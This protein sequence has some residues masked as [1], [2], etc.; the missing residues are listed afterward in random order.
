MATAVLAA[1]AGAESVTACTRDSR[2]GR[3][4]DI[5]S[6]TL[7]LGSLFNVANRIS[8]S[9][10]PA[11]E[12]S[13]AADIVTNLGFLRPISRDLIRK[14]PS[15]AAIALMWEPW[16]FRKEDIDLEACGDYGIPVVAT[17]E[18]HPNISTFRSVG[19]LALKLL[20]EKQCEII[21]LN[22]TVVGSDPFGNACGDVLQSVG[23]TVTVIDPQDDW[24]SKCAA[25]AIDESDGIVLAEHRYQG[26]L[27]GLSTSAFVSVIRQRSIPL[28]HIC[29]VVDDDYL[30]HCGIEKYPNNS[31]PYGFMTQTTA[32]V[33]SKPVVDLHAAGLHVA[34][35]VSRARLKGVSI[36]GAIDEAVTSGYGLRLELDK[37]NA[38][39]NMSTMCKQNGKKI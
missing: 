29:G 9:S 22:I 14:L 7:R 16:E 2:W 31:V 36:D 33:G 30:T 38:K 26:E 10:S 15:H 19:L 34:S 1:V 8:I 18:R 20:L 12:L 24:P 4:E 27:L 6:T 11:V 13:S 17:N 25:I 5:K 32:Y 28:V 39:I 23:A 3:F 37:I 35:I 21:G